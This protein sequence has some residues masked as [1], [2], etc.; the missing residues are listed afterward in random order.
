MR[1]RASLLVAVPVIAV[2]LAG[3]GGD[4]DGG[5]TTEAAPVATTEAPAT[6]AKEDLI[7]QG[8]AICAEVNA[9]VGTVNASETDTAD[10]VSQAAD[11]Y[12]GMVDRLQSLGQ[13]EEA[14]GY[15][16]FT[17]AADALA[18]AE[19]DALLAAEREDEEGL[20]SAQE[21]VA[22]ALATF[23]EAAAAYGFEDCAEAPSAPVPG[24]GAEG[25]EE[26]VAP[27]EVAPE[28]EAAPEEAAPEEEA[29]ETGGAGGGVGEGGG[30]AEPAPEEGGGG[31]GGIGPG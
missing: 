15:D 10:Q 27:E 14:E 24:A 30:T 28:E 4:D 3:C 20:L 31:S 17:A 8:D 5:D 7:T 29:P 1:T 26:E 2:A 12:G 18:Q 11:L 9:A 23:Q 16:D 22:S 25:S 13:P 21:E 6:L 19:S